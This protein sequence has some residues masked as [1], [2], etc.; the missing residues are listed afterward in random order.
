M[1][2]NQRNDFHQHFVNFFRN[3]LSECTRNINSSNVVNVV[4][5]YCQLHDRLHIFTF[6]VSGIKLHVFRILYFLQTLAK[7]LKKKLDAAR[8][9]R[10]M[11]GTRKEDTSAAEEEETVILTRTD[12]QGFVRPL[13]QFGQHAEPEGG[14]RRKQKIETHAGGKRMRYFADDDK[15]SLQ[16]LVCF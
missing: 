15:Y 1:L 16:D 6:F 11:R 8:A 9:A 7:E 13:Q 12:S 10:T 5:Y 2:S 14:R 4:T 3:S